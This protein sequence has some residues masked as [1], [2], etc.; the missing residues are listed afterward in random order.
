[1]KQSAGLLLWQAT[2]AGVEV[3][4]VHPSGAYNAKAPYGIP[5]GELDEGETPSEAAR[6]EVLEETGIDA[7]PPYIELGHVDYKKIRKRIHAFAA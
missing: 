6:R 3:L 5:K 1:M 4:L 2:E 7:P